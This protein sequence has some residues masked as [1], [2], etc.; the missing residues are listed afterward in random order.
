MQDGKLTDKGL[1]EIRSRLPDADLS[2]INK[3]RRLSAFSDLL[4]VDLVANYVAW[5]LGG[6]SGE[7]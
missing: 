3:D 7:K 4:T 2:D 6:G 1:A 5:K